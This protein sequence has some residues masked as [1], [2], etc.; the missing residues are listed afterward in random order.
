MIAKYDGQY[1]GEQGRKLFNIINLKN[2]INVQYI[3]LR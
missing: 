2:N 3:L 1:D